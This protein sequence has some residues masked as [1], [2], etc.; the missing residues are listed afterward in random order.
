MAKK[1]LSEKQRQHL[2]RLNSLPQTIANRFKKGEKRRPW[3]YGLGKWVTK[4]CQ[5]CGKEFEIREKEAA[6]GRGKYCSKECFYNAKKKFSKRRK[7]YELYLQGL[8]YKEIGKMLNMNPHTVA[9][10]VYVQKL[11][12]RYGDGIVSTATKG[13]LKRLLGEQGINECELC[14]YNRVV[15]IAHVIPRTQGGKMLLNNVLLLCPNCH[16]LFDHDLLYD[17]EKRKL[18]AIERVQKALKERWGISDAQSIE[19]SKTAYGNVIS[20]Q[21]R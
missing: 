9:Y 6:R 15:E 10:Y 13:R 3:N 12:N 1:P 8:S 2:E 17:E 18:L 19:I 14:G 20:L 5:F 21:E 16:H 11:C 7:V 4:I